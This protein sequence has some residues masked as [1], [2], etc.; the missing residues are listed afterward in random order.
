VTIAPPYS[1]RAARRSDCRRIAELYRISADGVAD[2]IWTKLA[3]PGEDLLEVGRRRY[4]REGTPFSYENC[5]LVECDGAIVGMLVAFP[6]VSDG[7][8]DE[9]DP[10]LAPYAR[11]EEDASYYVCGMAVEPPHRGR[12]IGRGLLAEAQRTARELGYGKLSLI[13]FEGNEGARRLYERSGFVAT[14][15]EPVV[16]HPLIRYTGNALLMVKAL[17]PR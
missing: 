17:G 8:S 15:R 3:R 16:P 7:K 12:G 9:P 1:I 13:V 11:L 2:Y 6:M 10:V 14:M 5:R 4:A